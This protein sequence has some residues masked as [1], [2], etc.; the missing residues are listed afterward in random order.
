MKT[1]LAWHN[2][3]HDMSRTAIALG[4]V[5]FAVVLMLMQLGFYNSATLTATMIYKRLDFDI[6]LVSPDYQNLSFPGSFSRRR[7]DQ[8]A[9]AEGVAAT[10]P[11]Y[12]GFQ[13]WSYP[14]ADN[15]PDRDPS[16]DR[17][18][19]SI[20]IFGTDVD[21]TAFN[22][23][24]VNEQRDRLRRTGNV[25]ID[26][27][28]RD[29]FGPKDVGV[30]T[31]V[32][33]QRIE[34][35]GQFTMGTG[36][37]ADGCLIGSTRTYCSLTQSSV[38]QVHLGLIR[39]AAGADAATVAARLKE[40]YPLGDCVVRTRAEVEAEERNYWVQKTS[41]GV[42]FACGVIVAFIVGTAIV[43]QVLSADISYR[44]SE[45][46][47]AKAIGYGNGYLS[48]VVLTQALI[49]AVVGYFPGWAIAWVLYRGTQIVARI[50][51]EL[52][53]FLTFSVLGLS[54]LMCM[55]SGMLALRK[56]HAADPADLF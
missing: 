8:A 24:E 2:L 5:M 13:L 40:L 6:L 45:Y 38:D 33:G 48:Q 41:V 15:R 19:R 54:I 36:F 55:V 7:L 12:I 3:T 39:I 30:A 49:L 31:E 51:M 47:T 34:I 23:A 1:P 37:G 46:A 53:L 50:P 17:R 4:G 29:E 26:R 42:I 11:L 27:M 28:S 43:Y 16:D 44:L 35:V 21:E 52:D 14:N 18:R 25:L 20:M 22:L 10:T 56:L 9:A 32:G